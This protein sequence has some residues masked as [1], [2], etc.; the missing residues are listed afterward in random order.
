MSQVNYQIPAYTR[1]QLVPS[2]RFQLVPSTR[3]QLVPGTR[4]QLVP[5]SSFFELSLPS[6]VFIYFL[7]DILEPE[8][9]P[10][11]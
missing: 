1:F 4:F 11:G 10:L 8:Q 2:T 7:K 5:D 9:K 6:L 3:F